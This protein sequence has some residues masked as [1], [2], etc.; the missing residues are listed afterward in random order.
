MN[1][2]KSTHFA[3]LWAIALLLFGGPSVAQQFRAATTPNEFAPAPNEPQ[4]AGGGGTDPTQPPQ[5]SQMLRWTLPVGVDFTTNP[6]T[7]FFVPNLVDDGNLS[8]SAFDEE[9]RLL[10]FVKY[11]AQPNAILFDGNGIQ[12]G[13][14]P[15]YQSTSRVNQNG[16]PHVYSEWGREM[17]VV[18]VPGVCKQFYL[19]YVQSSVIPSLTCCPSYS[20]LLRATIDCRG[21][22]PVVL[23][24]PTPVDESLSE[25]F[26]GIAVSKE[27]NGIRRLY[28][29]NYAN[30]S[31]YVISSSGVSA[32][33]RY[34]L[35]N[36]Q[37]QPLEADLSPDGTRLAMTCSK[38]SGGVYL[39][40]INPST[41]V[42]SN[43]RS[44]GIANAQTFG[45]EFSPDSKKLYYSGQTSS[46]GGIYELTLA[47]NGSQQIV[48]TLANAC[49]GSQLELAYD[50]LIYAGDDQDRLVSL[51][52]ATNAVALATSGGIVRRVPPY[53]NSVPNRTAL[54]TRALPDQI[55]GQDYSYFFGLPAPQVSNLLGGGKLLG[56]RFRN[57]YTCQAPLP[58][59]AS[60]TNVLE[61]RVTVQQAEAS[62]A[63]VAGGYQNQTLW[64]P[65]NTSFDLAT[66]FA[67]YLTNTPDYYQIT[68]E[69]RNSCGN[70]NRRIGL[71][72]INNETLTAKFD[73]ITGTE[74]EE[75]VPS[76]DPN[77]PS[78]VG[79][80]GGAV[81]FTGNYAFD[82]YKA[83]IEEYS[84]GNLTPICNVG[85]VSVPFGTTI[86]RLNDIVNNSLAPNSYAGYPDYFA[87]HLGRV[88]K[89]SISLL[90]PC[91]V[92]NEEIGYFT[93]VSSS[94]LSTPVNNG[95]APSAFSAYP[96]PVNNNQ[97]RVEY[98]L[99]TAQ[100]VQV[101]VVD[102]LTGQQRLLPL[103]RTWQAAG[104]HRLDIDL[105]S[106]PAGAYLYRIE[107]EQSVSK[108]FIK[109]DQ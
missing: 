17:A 9:K 71:I 72:R 100:S 31:S 57:L 89:I 75:L 80:I 99:P 22:T 66:I 95:N 11:G 62:G 15:A 35:T 94:Y 13:S 56:S 12:R 55:D 38:S 14:L 59:T 74:G 73:F 102:A 37:M 97:M 82:S 103:P 104:P 24:P 30:I 108:R 34:N 88:Y 36:L 44:G 51:N 10:F 107:A 47:T 39:A 54:V 29:V 63:V 79:G 50:G 48:N 68:F 2:P 109:S 65:S 105:S 83:V 49:F 7:L 93:P 28:F 91:A 76:V 3:Y 21:T 16:I 26:Y 20:V 33:T 41:G 52:P 53:C 92:T 19:F 5:P 8:A 4:N 69:G 78:E 18:P 32:A 58:L 43:L 46:S 70:I 25:P 27:T 98:V 90:S 81:H 77:V 42:V 23:S 40:D 64:V 60:L 84:N 1:M 6:G 85:P 45:V 96:N 101:R 106:L 87:Q 86:I 67:G 61:V